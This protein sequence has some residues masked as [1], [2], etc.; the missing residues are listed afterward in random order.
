MVDVGRPHC[1][2]SLGRIYGR[3]PAATD[4]KLMDI[5][6][7]TKVGSGNVDWRI[8]LVGLFAAV[9]LAAL[10]QFESIPQDLSYHNFAD[11]RPLLGIPN[12]LDVLSN[13]SFLLV[14]IYGYFVLTRLE[15]RK[16]HPAWAVFVAGVFLVGLG[17]SFY[18]FAPDNGSLVWDRLPMTIGFMGLFV[19]LLSEFT[20]VR[21]GVAS[22]ATAVLVGI[23]SVVYWAAADDLRF[24]AWVQFMP[25]GAVVILLLT[26]GSRITRSWILGLALA[27]YVCAKFA[28]HFDVEIFNALGG[29]TSGH[30]LKHLFAAAGCYTVLLY[31]QQRSLK[32]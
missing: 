29:I 19:A 9:S 20:G 11:T 5:P 23:S 14:G 18:H 25:L 1:W 4:E 12:G 13:I 24:Y 27:L 6:H 30:T 21:L 7:I 22:L 26:C 3:Q 28:E 2:C 16:W 32:N 15:R 31:L 10:F 17:S 8:L